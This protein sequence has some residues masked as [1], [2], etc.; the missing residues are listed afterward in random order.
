MPFFFTA[1]HYWAAWLAIGALL[2]A[3]RRQ[4]ADHPGRAWPA[5]RP[6]AATAAAGGLTRRGAARRGRRARPASSPSPRSGRPSRPLAPR[7]AARAAPPARRAA[8]PAGQQD[9]RRGRRPRRGARPGYRLIVAGPAGDGRAHPRRPA[10]AAAAHR[11]PADRLRRGLER[12]PRTWTGVRLRDLVALV[13]ADPDR[14]EAYVESLRGARP[15]PDVDRGRRRTLRDPL[16][17]IALRLNGE[18]LH[19]DHG[20]P[21][22]L[23][24]PNRPGV[25][26]TK[27]VA[28]DHRAGARDVRRGGSDRRRHAV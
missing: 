17:L 6:P 26:Q 25:L 21:A 7:L 1:A 18:P 22:R 2:V 13:G 3:H 15:L 4:A 16:T 9:R 19:P 11:R 23:I 28:P 8:A 27:W 10:G 12:R 24:A 20:Y 5:D 14:A